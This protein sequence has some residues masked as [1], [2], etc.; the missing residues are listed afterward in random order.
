[1]LQKG[2]FG[3]HDRFERVWSAHMQVCYRLRNKENIKVFLHR[4]L[5]LPIKML[6]LFTSYMARLR[7]A[8][9]PEISV[10]RD[11]SLSF[12]CVYSGCWSISPIGDQ[13]GNIEHKHSLAAVGYANRQHVRLVW[14]ERARA[15]TQPY[16]H[17]RTSRLAHRYAPYTHTHVHTLTHRKH[18]HGTRSQTRPDGAVKKT[19]QKC[20]GK[21]S[22]WAKLTSSQFLSR[23]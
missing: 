2:S 16:A 7:L 3:F 1:M 6:D 4:T 20:K 17:S 9:T 12:Y 8:R 13:Q 14:L 11:V 15:H 10:L 21:G 19:V 5:F 18:P 22:L 23:Y